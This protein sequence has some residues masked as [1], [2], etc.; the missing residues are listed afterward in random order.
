MKKLYVIE[1][2]FIDMTIVLICAKI[3]NKR[4]FDTQRNKYFS[5]ITASIFCPQGSIFIISE[6]WYLKRMVVDV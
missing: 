1:Q 2:Q 4:F 6:I 5:I 3:I